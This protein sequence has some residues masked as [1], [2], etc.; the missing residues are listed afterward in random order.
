MKFSEYKDLSVLTTT[1]DSIAQQLV[2]LY[3]KTINDIYGEAYL[4]MF[5]HTTLDNFT[6]STNGIINALYYLNY[7]LEATRKTITFWDAYQIYSTISDRDTV[8]GQ[9]AN[10]PI[11][12]SLVSNLR[13]P[14]QW[15]NANNQLE[16]VY[17]G[18][19][20][21]KDHNGTTHLVHGLSQGSYRPS[22]NWTASP[23]GSNTY[24]LTYTYTEGIQVGDTITTELVLEDTT[25]QG[26]N[27]T[28][29]IAAASGS[30]PTTITKNIITSGGD[31]IKP[32]VKYFLANSNGYEQVFLDTAYID[33]TTTFTLKNP[34]PVALVYEVK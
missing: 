18:D 2:T 33:N 20:F 23:T 17:Q 14:F 27:E 10:L 25:V 16:T 28:G 1:S 13:D 30:T 9:I 26:Y 15:F 6:D 32:V 34:T 8:L 12:S 7:K 19:L 31:R 3:S 11:N 22:Q 4:D 24:V 21:I 29:T 5:S